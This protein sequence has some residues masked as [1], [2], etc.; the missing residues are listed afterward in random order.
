M[1]NSP[2]A[3]LTEA[4]FKALIDLVVAYTGRE[5][6]KTLIETWAA[7]AGIGRWAYPEAARAIHLWVA[8][9]KPQDFLEPSDITRAIRSIRNKAAATF[10]DPVIPEGQPTSEYLAWYR[11]QQKAHVAALVH[12]WATT[13]VEPPAQLQS[14]KPA[15]QLGQRRL[16]ELTAGAFHDMPSAG[17]DGTPPTVEAVED[18]R[19]AF[20]VACPYCSARPGHPCTRSGISGRT[21]RLKHPHPARETR[22]AEEAS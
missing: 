5:P 19:S 15:N 7:Q 10:E 22:P 9:R 11:A 4:D 16:A 14:A 2:T 20:A 6:D 3:T 12:R 21:T 1:T 18:R 8:N 13:G 17:R